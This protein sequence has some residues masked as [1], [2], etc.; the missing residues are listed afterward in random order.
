MP[1]D[2]RLAAGG[3]HLVERP[4][5]GGTRFQLGLNLGPVDALVPLH[6]LLEAGFQCVEKLGGAFA[7][8]FVLV[9]R[10]RFAGGRLFH[11]NPVWWE[12]SADR[13]PGE[14]SSSCQFQ[15]KPPDDSV[16]A[17][18]KFGSRSG[19]LFGL[20][21]GVWPIQVLEDRDPVRDGPWIC[22]DGMCGLVLRTRSD[23]ASE[24]VL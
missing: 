14:Y 11:S 18:M 23:R 12:S 21:S 15:P 7:R 10:F 3:F 8:E 4:E 24:L 5:L 2:V 20:R 9:A 17:G 22:C 6:I 16:P 19:M 13:R 1:D